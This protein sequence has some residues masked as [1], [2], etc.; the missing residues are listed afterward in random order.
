MT[1]RADGRFLDAVGCGQSVNAPFELSRDLCM[2]GSAGAGLVEPVDR[3]RRIRM[4]QRRVCR[5]AIAATRTMLTTDYCSGMH[6]GRIGLNGSDCANT[7]WCWLSGAM[8][9]PAGL[10]LVTGVY[11]RGWVTRQRHGMGITVTTCAA[12]ELCVREAM[13]G[14][15]AV[16]ALGMRD[17]RI[18]MTVAAVHRIESAP[19]SSVAANVA[20][21]TLRIAVWGALEESQIYFVAIVTGVF[22]LSVGR[23]QHEQ[24][25]KNQ[26]RGEF[27]HRC[28]HR[29][30][31]GLPSSVAEQHCVNNQ[32]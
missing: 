23:L 16:H 17:E 7:R 10:P 21:E 13:Q 4:W 1:V 6:A 24:R 14:R 20:V 15:L 29:F 18:A 5:M 32:A 30:S 25:T 26:N 9:D 31:F 3:R 8:A 28:H 27:A 2:T 12:W 11:R 22:L 19:V